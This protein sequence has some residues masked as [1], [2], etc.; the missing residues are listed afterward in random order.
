VV[1]VFQEILTSLILKLL[2]QIRPLLALHHD[3]LEKLEIGI[4]RPGQP[5]FLI[6]VLLDIRVKL[7]DPALPALLRLSVQVLGRSLA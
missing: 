1:T 5:R 7:I 6:V 3:F 2:G 4:F